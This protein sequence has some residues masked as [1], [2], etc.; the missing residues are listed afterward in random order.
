MAPVSD[1]RWWTLP[2]RDLLLLPLIALATAILLLVPAELIVRQQHPAVLVDTCIVETATTSVVNHGKPNCVSQTKTAE[3]PWVTNR[4][5]ACGYRSSE[6]CG[7]KPAGSLRVAVVGSSTAAGF[8]TPYA[9]TMA[10]RSARALTVRC[11]RP[12][13]FQ[14]LGAYGNIGERLVLS[15][16]EAM[17]LT[18]DAMVVA[19]DPFDFDPSGALADIGAAPGLKRSVLARVRERISSS[20]LLYMESYYLLREDASYLPLYLGLAHGADFMRVPMPPKWRKSVEAFD[21]AIAQVAAVARARSVPV[22]V[23]FVPQRAQAVLA[24]SRRPN[25]QFDPRAFPK[26]LERIAHSHGV[27]FVD[28]TLEIPKDTP[29]ADIFYAVN[30]HINGRGHEFVSHALIRAM[31]ESG[32]TSF[33]QRCEPAGQGYAE[34]QPPV[35]FR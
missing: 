27:A 35:H 11:G 34:R 26:L 2:R 31:T 12:V 29:S 3:G 16:R 1:R 4:Y 25:A 21:H 17:T 32:M 7:A 20:S 18:P 8:L 13:E 23:V 5:N 10:A 15:A 6:P 33:A 22:L 28:S 30:S 14:N 24:S 9:D 19:I